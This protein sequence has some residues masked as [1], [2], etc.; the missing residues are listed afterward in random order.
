[1]ITIA[2]SS[3]IIEIEI[4]TDIVVGFKIKPSVSSILKKTLLGHWSQETLSSQFVASLSLVPSNAQVSPSFSEKLNSFA[5]KQQHF[6]FCWKDLGTEAVRGKNTYF[7]FWEQRVGWIKISLRFACSDWSKFS[8][9]ASDW[10]INRK[11][12]DSDSTNDQQCRE[13]KR[14]SVA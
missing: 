5:V 2:S 13:S 3:N 4:A 10:L 14:D 12:K 11:R 7:V 8:E 6:E 1:M 9:I